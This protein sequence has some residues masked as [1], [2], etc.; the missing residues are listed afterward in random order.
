MDLVRKVAT[1]Y[2]SRTRPA[3]RAV[4]AND[5]TKRQR[6]VD[7]ALMIQKKHGFDVASVFLL[8]YQFRLSQIP[9]LLRGT[10]KIVSIKALNTTKVCPT[11]GRPKEIPATGAVISQLS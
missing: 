6:L 9:D 1:P 4:S 11:P 3:S 7:E 5:L 10:S 2:L 8:N